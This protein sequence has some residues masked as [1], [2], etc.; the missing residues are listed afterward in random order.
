MYYKSK[1]IVIN[2]VQVTCAIQSWQLLAVKYLNRFLLLS[3]VKLIQS[4]LVFSLLY[5]EP[6]QYLIKIFALKQRSM[7][8]NPSKFQKTGCPNYFTDRHRIRNVM[9]RIWN[10]FY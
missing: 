6:K 5:P 4:L 8:Y 2:K 7:L 10:I 3:K 9:T 1:N